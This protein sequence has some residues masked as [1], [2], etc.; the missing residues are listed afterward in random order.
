MCLALSFRHKLAFHCVPHAPDWS[1]GL[2]SCHFSAGRRPVCPSLRWLRIWSCHVD[3]RRRGEARG[4]GGRSRIAWHRVDLW[5]LYNEEVM[6][7]S[8]FQLNIEAVVLLVLFLVLLVLFLV[9]PSRHPCPTLHPFFFLLL[10]GACLNHQRVARSFL[11]LH[12]CGSCNVASVSP[13]VGRRS[14]TH[15]IEGRTCQARGS[16]PFPTHPLYPLFLCAL[17]CLFFTSCLFS[18]RRAH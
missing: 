1:R 8:M 16:H 17:P 9:S 3:P 2:L 14:F 13:F 15:D 5:L 4:R 10:T 6:V 12:V 18:G 7:M 11:L